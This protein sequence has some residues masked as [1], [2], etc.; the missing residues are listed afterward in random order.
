[1]MVEKSS[2]GKEKLL[3]CVNENCPGKGDS[4]KVPGK[5]KDKDKERVSGKANKTTREK[6]TWQIT[7]K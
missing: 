2:R 3:I 4:A 6:K 7:E 1:M 5:G